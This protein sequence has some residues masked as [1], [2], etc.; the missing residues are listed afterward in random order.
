MNR[1]IL[2]PVALGLGLIAALTLTG[3][4][5]QD[6]SEPT[7]KPSASSAPET[8]DYGTCVNDQVT[9]LASQA[10]AGETVEVGACPSVAIVDSAKDGVVFKIGAVDKLVIEGS[11]ITAQVESATSV[12]VPGSENTVTYGGQSQ[13]EDIGAGNTVSAA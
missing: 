10:K 5:S 13:V 1:T 3:C 12:V 8:V 4:S 7:T 2:K 9:I 11:H 6:T